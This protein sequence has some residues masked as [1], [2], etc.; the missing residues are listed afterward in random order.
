MAPDPMRML[1]SLASSLSGVVMLLGAGLAEVLTKEVEAST[2]RATAMIVAV[3]KSLKLL[4][5]NMM[6]VVYCLKKSL[7]NP[8][9][10]Y[11]RDLYMMAAECQTT[12]PLPCCDHSVDNLPL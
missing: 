5:T 1:I 12:G 9:S 11:R 8:P 4:W 2:P 10:P 3:P 7:M 6:V